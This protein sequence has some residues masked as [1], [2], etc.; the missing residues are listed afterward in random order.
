MPQYSAFPAEQIAQA[1]DELLARG[2]VPPIY[3]AAVASNGCMY[4]VEFYGDVVGGFE[5]QKHA[6][7]NVAPGFRTP[8]NIIFVDQRGEAARVV[9]EGPDAEPEVVQ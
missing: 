8:V 7:H 3:C 6:E 5:V 9:L 4:F 2:F 1:L